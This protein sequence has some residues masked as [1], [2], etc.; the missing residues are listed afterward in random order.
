[1]GQYIPSQEEMENPE[2]YLKGVRR[3]HRIRIILMSVGMFLFWLM[4]GVLILLMKK[5]GG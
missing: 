1:M 5:S 3:R 4:V 2:K